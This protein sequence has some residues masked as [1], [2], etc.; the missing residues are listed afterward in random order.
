MDRRKALVAKRYEI[1]PLLQV[2]FWKPLRSVMEIF[3][4]LP[5]SAGVV[6]FILFAIDG[7]FREIYI[8]YL[9]GPNG[10]L[11]G[12]IVSFVAAGVVLALL[13]SL[14]YEAHFALSTLRIR[15]VYSGYSNPDANS[16][17]RKL[18][19]TG[20]FVLAILPWLGIAIGLFNAR[21]FVANRY[22]QLLSQM[23]A[24]DLDHMQH[25]LVPKGRAIAAALVF[26]G[27]ATAT[28][29]CVD[30]KS[31]VAQ[32]AVALI[33]QPL[34]VLLFLLFVNWLVLDI[35]DRLSILACAIALVITV[36]YFIIYQSLY[37]HRRGPF[38]VRPPAGFAERSEVAPPIKVPNTQAK[39]LLSWVLLPIRLLF[40][41]REFATG[42]SFGKRQ[43]YELAVWAFFPWLAYACY[44]AAVP[45]RVPSVTQSLCPLAAAAFP[46]L[47][48]QW[49]VFP[50]AMCC[51]IAFGLLVGLVLNMTS[52]QWKSW[53]GIVIRRGFVVLGLIIVLGLAAKAFA[54]FASA[55]TVVWFYR[56]IGPLATVAL[57]LV[58]L[59]TLFAVLAW[60][61]QRS[62]F[63][64]LSLAILAIVA[65]VMFPNH[66]GV[67]ALLLGLA[68]G[69]FAIAGFLAGDLAVG[70][71]AVLLIIFG[72]TQWYE[73]L[74]EVVV[75]QN[76]APPNPPAKSAAT[77]DTHG[78]KFQFECWLRS[79][80]IPVDD[81][82]AA[83]CPAASHATVGSAATVAPGQDYVVYI[84]A[85]EGGGIYAASAASMLLARLQ[86]SSSHFAEHVFAI[87]GV[88]GGAIGST[89][90]QALDWAT[91]G[92]PPPV[93]VTTA[94]GDPAPCP[95]SSVAEERRQSTGQ[96]LED[97][98]TCIMEDDHFS[99]V[100]G[101]I[102]AEITG[103]STGRA[104]ALVASFND[105]VSSY[106]P[107]A[108][109][110]L[111][112]PFTKSWSFRSNVPALVLNSTWVETGFRVAFAPFHLHDIDA[113]LYSFSDP[114][115]PNESDKSLMEAAAV[116]ARFPLV[117]PPFSAVMPAQESE[118]NDPKPKD[119][120]RWNF[121]DGGYS[122]NSG[123]TTALDL[124]K[125]LSSVAPKGVNVRIILLTSSQ[126]HPDLSGPKIN[127]TA[128]RDTMG[129]I[130]A[131]M[132]VRE[133]LGNQAVALACSQI[134]G[135]LKANANDLCSQHAGESA[136]P[137]QIIEIQDETYGLS[138][139]W[140]ISQTSFDVVSWMLG[141]PD[142][143]VS[144]QQPAAHPLPP[145]NV[146]ASTE[147]KD[148]PTSQ[149]PGQGTDNS[150]LTDD[151]L[152]RNSCVLKSIKDSV[153]G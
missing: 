81:G 126:V 136:A 10:D 49:A 44:F 89:V 75:E 97:K 56:L 117:L 110:E 27:A 65:C 128:F 91:T 124:Y 87:S 83:E 1:P 114:S 70:F 14:L 132:S 42:I 7:Q 109:Q 9:E 113:S 23:L 12:W 98:V 139:G 84:I 5:L 39:R 118:T 153:P 120:K 11:A 142:E 22:C 37:E 15:V 140:K 29:S 86:D 19:R 54:F 78:V 82:A 51:V 58:F 59:I 107:K 148:A 146:P 71:V 3:H 40:N 53:H 36:F 127:G 41:R 30:Q 147:A 152:K 137:L 134:Y 48:G 135:T 57:Q 8:S 68:C 43:R 66:V 145:S 94:L 76:P 47:P 92:E 106:D 102:F 73:M 13:S 20:A 88:S 119:L 111:S 72:L 63:P 116:S 25:L 129:P 80:G 55:D 67:V 46:P 50:V 38:F 131:L 16:N 103:S 18:Q 138:L 100:I 95:K 90:F 32:R 79:R 69:V 130:D 33:A 85:A 21:N 35:T 115:M 17:P 52:E 74:S 77:V 6:C 34:G 96:V 31:R 125:A 123:A 133:D 26:L 143:C 93:P 144:S 150:Q 122:D 24:D 28:F 61:S 149:P 112:S 105:S 108:G 104:E 99:P 141:E 121:V 64:V 62:G 4:L 101:S 2:R 151:I 60:L 45:D